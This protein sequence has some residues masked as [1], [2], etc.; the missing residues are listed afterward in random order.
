MTRLTFLN[1]CLIIVS[2]S[3]SAI[4][5]IL[6]KYNMYLDTIMLLTVTDT[7][8]LHA[9]SQCRLVHVY[10]QYHSLWLINE[11]IFKLHIKQI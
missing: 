9:V 1:H 11:N 7:K 8:I 2:C 4:T 10:K 3:K 6:N 5:N